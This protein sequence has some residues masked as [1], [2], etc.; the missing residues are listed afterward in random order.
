LQQP[1]VNEGAVRL[2]ATLAGSVRYR[3]HTKPLYDHTK[4]TLSRRPTAN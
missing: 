4:S 3:P 2:H 1:Y